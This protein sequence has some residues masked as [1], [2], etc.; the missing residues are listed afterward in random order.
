MPKDGSPI[1]ML[2]IEEKPNSFIPINISE[3]GIKLRIPNY[4]SLKQMD[5]IIFNYGIDYLKETLRVSNITDS[6]K[7]DGDFVILLGAIY[8]K[9]KLPII[10]KEI[11]ETY[12]LGQL[13]INNIN[14]KEFV[15]QVINKIKNLKNEDPI[16]CNLNS[17]L[18]SGNANLFLI[19]YDTLPY[20][21]QRDIYWL[22]INVIIKLEE[23]DVIVRERKEVE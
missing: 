21:V 17:I 16:N 4:C 1:C 18:K 8:G 23:K 3:L 15:N 12:N 9:R 22:V 20:L 7:L 19:Y 11:R 2:A 10:T 5:N 13:I 6:D 14:N